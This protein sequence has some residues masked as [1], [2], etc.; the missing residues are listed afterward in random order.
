V[1][2]RLAEQ[3]FDLI[4]MDVEM[5]ELDGLE[6]TV[7]IRNLENETNTHVPIIALTARAMKPDRDL[8]LQAGMDDY[9]SKPIHQADLMQ[10]LARYLPKKRATRAAHSS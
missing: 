5:P 7:C 9:I 1:L 4:L 2:A 10:V 6:T 8:C 3:T